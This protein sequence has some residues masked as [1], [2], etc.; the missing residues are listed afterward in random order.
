MKGGDGGASFAANTQIIKDYQTFYNLPDNATPGCNFAS[1]YSYCF[2]GGF[3]NVS[4]RSDGS[5]HVLGSSSEY[6]NVNTDG[7]SACTEL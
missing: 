3:Y 7:Y 4:A 6:C 1:S 2:G 5:V